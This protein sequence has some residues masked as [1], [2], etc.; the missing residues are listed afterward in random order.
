M[1]QPFLSI[2]IPAHNE[3]KRLPPSLKTID[4][5]LEKQSYESEILVIENGSQDLTAIVTE[6]FAA[7]HPRV[8]LFQE[9]GRGKGLAV[10]A[11]MLKARGEYRFICDADL[12]MPIEEL[13]KFLPPERNDYD[14]AIGSREV[15]G[16]RR[17]NEPPYR[18]FQG[19]VFST[20]VKVFA[21]PG[22]EDT[23]CGFK[24]FRGS[25]A[26]DIFRAQVF[27]GMSF[28]VEALFI[29]RKRG[30]K[31]IEVPI[32]WYY[33]AES[34]VHPILDPLRMLRDILVIRSNW[35]R[36]LYKG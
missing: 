12:S 13:T 4:A 35:S 30:Y 21:L 8:K 15:A 32:D 10:R 1:T 9:A 33:R 23:Q 27:N 5:F 7:D 11:G 22:F 6:A 25:I 19:R 18:H 36:G 24:M 26:E 3:E 28:D 16:A 14:V 29:A 2:I 20:L 34:R 31:I 17:F